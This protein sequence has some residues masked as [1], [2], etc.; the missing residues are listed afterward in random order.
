MYVNGKPSPQE[1]EDI[2][3]EEEELLS[4]PPTLEEQPQV[5]DAD[6]AGYNPEIELWTLMLAAQ[7]L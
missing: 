6:D 4:L 2:F 1:M 3:K 7:N 5:E